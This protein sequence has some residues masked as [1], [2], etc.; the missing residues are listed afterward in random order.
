[1]HS[2]TLPYLHTVPCVCVCAF[3]LFLIKHLPCATRPF[4]SQCAGFHFR[5]KCNLMKNYFF[6]RSIQLKMQ[7]K[8]EIRNVNFE[9]KK[10]I[11]NIPPFFSC[12]FLVQIMV[13]T[14]KL[15]AIFNSVEQSIQMK[16]NFMN[17]WKRK[18]NSSKKISSVWRWYSQKTC[19]T[20]D[21]S[22]DS[23]MKRN[24]E[25]KIS[26]NPME[27]PEKRIWPIPCMGHN[28]F[29][30]INLG[31]VWRQNCSTMH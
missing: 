25:H 3:F 8:N 6:H 22:W 29:A 2:H 12:F 10:L 4:D 31:K 5:A 11:W 20:L 15:I 30:C 19:S 26:V 9:G 21:H 14:V 24:I 27:S 13:K 1:M 17:N 28:E 23:L 18:K 7:L 16:T